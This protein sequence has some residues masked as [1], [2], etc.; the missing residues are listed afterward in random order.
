MKL[1]PA[2]I[3]PE[4]LHEGGWLRSDLPH[5]WYYFVKKPRH[6]TRSTDSAF[7]RTVDKPLRPLVRLLHGRGIATTPSCSGH[8][9]GP[10]QLHAIYVTLQQEA[11]AIRRDGLQLCDVETGGCRV[12]ADEKYKLPW[13][14]ALFA[15][16]VRRNQRLGVLGMRLGPRRKAKERIRALRIPHVHIEEHDRTLFIF[17]EAGTKAEIALLWRQVT[18][19]V[20]KALGPP[21]G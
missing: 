6:A 9:L 21:I 13:S 16:K 2:I 20:R 3:P 17:S 14:E 10:A 8:V 1:T 12:H 7:M 4:H 5:A 18:A 11:R 15:R 19:G